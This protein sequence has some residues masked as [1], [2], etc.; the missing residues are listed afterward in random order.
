MARQLH[1]SKRTVVRSLRELS[2]SGLITIH[3]RFNKDGTQ[4]ASMYTVSVDMIEE[5]ERAYAEDKTASKEV[6]M[7]E[8]SRKEIA[9][10]EEEIIVIEFDMTGKKQAPLVP[11]AT[12]EEEPAPEREPLEAIMNE[13]EMEDVFIDETPA[14]EFQEEAYEDALTQLMNSQ[15]KD[16]ERG[17]AEAL[18]IER[19]AVRAAS[20]CI[21][22]PEP[23]N[24]DLFDREAAAPIDRGRMNPVISASALP[25][26]VGTT[27]G[28]A[29]KVWTGVTKQVC[30]PSGKRDEIYEMLSLL[31]P[32]YES[33]QALVEYLTPFYTAW[34]SRK[35]KNGIRYSPTNPAWL[36]EWVLAGAIPNDNAQADAPKSKAR[37]W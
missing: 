30:T 12:I 6:T 37:V 8:L 35:N 7:I 32:K 1:I 10:S 20:Y 31:W 3:H 5:A 2:D 34:V 11:L 24:Y 9:S 22:G 17:K 15:R 19:N 23:E 29:E 25:Q 33:E 28:W 4:R 18:E 16:D 13:G 27:T 26:P 21:A 14:C 36:L